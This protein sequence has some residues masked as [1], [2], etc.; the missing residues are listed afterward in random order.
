MK[1]EKIE[2]E[3]KNICLDCKS[4]I[5]EL[6]SSFEL[7]KSEIALLNQPK[8]VFTFSVPLRRDDGST[9]IYNAYR[10]QYNDALGPTKGGIR[11]H[12]DVD[13]EEVKTLAF[14][15]ALKCSLV[16]LPLGGAKG[17]IDVDPGDLSKDELKRLTKGFV[18]EIHKF[19]G[20]DV[21][22]PAPDVN[23][24]A[25]IMRW[26]VEEY[27]T[28]KGVFTPAVITGKPLDIGGSLGRDSATG[29]GGA[30]VLHHYFEKTLR[31]KAVTVA[32]QGFGNVGG[33]IAHFLHKWGYTV[34][35]VSDA[36]GGL[37]KK[38]GLPIPAMLK[39]RGTTPGIRGCVQC[40]SITNKELLELDV[41]ILIPAALSHQITKENASDIKASV[42]LEMANAP[43][44]QEADVLLEER[45]VTIIRDIL[46]NAGG[47]IVSYYEWVQ[48]NE[49]V[50]WDEDKVHK[51]LKKKILHAFDALLS[52]SQNSSQSM[53]DVAYKMAIDRILK[54][55][56]KRGTLA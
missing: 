42:I 44:T 35:A 20:P 52:A 53:R 11:Y 56:K 6:S 29:L 49:G 4:R 47:V 38:E 32:I 48:N 9:K 30:F 46:A 39:A 43:V 31:K 12:P 22:I 19:I 40:D 41:D 51:K 54:A 36:K 10:V 18:R 25:E 55:E 21:D 23:T 28:L 45:N 2:R 16:K 15:M 33:H 14:L 13:I 17:G 5:E 7:S 3:N 27:S 50:C 34:V 1:K 8:R 24:N 37:Y 26:I